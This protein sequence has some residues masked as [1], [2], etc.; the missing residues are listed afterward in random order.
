MVRMTEYAAE[1]GELDVRL[2]NAPDV[3]TRQRRMTDAL[4]RAH[5]DL[6]AE[7]AIHLVRWWAGDPSDLRAAS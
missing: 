6:A 2:A 3:R 1:L 7:E 4:L 5:P